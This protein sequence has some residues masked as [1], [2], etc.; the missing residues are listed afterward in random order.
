VEPSDT[1]SPAGGGGA[2]GGSGGS[3]PLPWTGVGCRGLG[4]WFPMTALTF[5]PAAEIARAA[6]VDPRP[7]GWRDAGAILAAK[8]ASFVAGELLR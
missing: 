3:S 8:P 2:G 1:V 6:G 7:T 4:G 5:A